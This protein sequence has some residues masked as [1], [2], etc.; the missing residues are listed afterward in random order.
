MELDM[1]QC[2]LLVRDHAH[3]GGVQDEAMESEFITNVVYN[4]QCSP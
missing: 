3:L 2:S 1:T 4:L